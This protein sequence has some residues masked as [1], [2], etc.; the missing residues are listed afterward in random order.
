MIRKSLLCTSI[1]AMT[2]FEASKV[3][4]A[5][6]IIH[7]SR[8]FICFLIGVTAKTM[9]KKEVSKTAVWRCPICT[10]D[11]EDSMSE[12]DICGV[13]RNPLV[14]NNIKTDNVA[15]ITACPFTS[16]SIF[17]I[18]ILIFFSFSSVFFI[19]PGN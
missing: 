2:F 5:F 9:P 4:S 3:R 6:S 11:N 12:C 1:R 7:M 8:L 18:V 16:L 19:L 13:L 17:F 15:G 14:K 10:Y